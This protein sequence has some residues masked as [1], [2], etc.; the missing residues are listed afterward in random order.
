MPEARRIRVTVVYAEPEAA[1]TA[2]LWLPHGATVAEAIRRSGIREARPDVA[3][4]TGRVGIFARKASLDTPLRE[5]DRVEIYR[6]L[7]I[8]PKEARRL[9]AKSN[10]SANERK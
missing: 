8:D 6:P 3:T 4:G 10:P 1:F 5:G 9:R 2:T 7:Q